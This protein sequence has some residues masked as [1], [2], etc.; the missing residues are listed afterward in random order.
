M[1]DIF[2]ADVSFPEAP[3]VLPDG[4]FLIVE[5]GEGRG[6]ITW[7]SADGASRRTVAKTGRPNGL[8]VDR[9]QRIW[10]AETLQRALVRAS[11]DGDCERFADRFGDEEFLFLNDL[12]IASNGDIFLTDSGVAMEMIAP[13]GEL[14]PG[15]RE[16]DYDGRVYRID[17]RSGEVDRVDNGYLFTNGIA[18]GPDGSLYIAETLSGD[19]YRY[20][21]MDGRVTGGRELFTNVLISYD[22]AELKGPDGMKFGMDGKLYVAVFGQGDITVVDPGGEVVERLPVGGMWPTNLAFGPVGSE[23][24][25]VTEAET[26]TVRTARVGTDGLPLHA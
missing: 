8:A 20:P 19:I 18:F 7:I 11:L 15:Y 24:I 21:C 2:A 22:P 5:M 26:G 9:R 3:V 1:M 4:S 13:G 6:C 14:N 17:P 25:Y 23:R 16:L 12:A 10:V